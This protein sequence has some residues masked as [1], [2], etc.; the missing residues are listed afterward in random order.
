VLLKLLISFGQGGQGVE[1]L[2]CLLFRRCD[3]HVLIVSHHNY[4]RLHFE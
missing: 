3:L 4:L 2:G 1:F